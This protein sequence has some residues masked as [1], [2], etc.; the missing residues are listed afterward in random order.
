M[1]QQLAALQRLRALELRAHGAEERRVVEAEAGALGR[2]V[3]LQE[4]TLWLACQVGSI[5][6]GR[7][8]ATKVAHAVPA[9]C[10]VRLHRLMA[11]N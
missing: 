2:L 6:A 8:L 4:L 3:Q 5:E 1:A 7:D 9:G 10:R 11:F